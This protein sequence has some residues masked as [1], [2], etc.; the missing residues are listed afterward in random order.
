[1]F[2]ALVLSMKVG[3]YSDRQTDR[4]G[5]LHKQMGRTV[6][7]QREMGSVQTDRIAQTDR[8]DCAREGTAPSRIPNLIFTVCVCLFSSE[9][10]SLEISSLT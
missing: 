3:L 10:D 6:H 4:W 2:N 1:M 9:G 8:E 5:G 7:R